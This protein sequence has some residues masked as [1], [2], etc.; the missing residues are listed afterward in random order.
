MADDL[1]DAQGVAEDAAETNT[2]AV[3]LA[4]DGAAD[5]RFGRAVAENRSIPFAYTDWGRALK[6]RGNI[7]G[8]IAKF[9]IAHDKAPHFADPLEIWGEALIAQNRSDLALAKFEEANKYAPNWGR[10]HLKWGEALW[11]SGDKDGARKQFAAASHLD[12]APAEQSQL[13]KFA[14]D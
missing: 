5:W 13:A 7:D 9:A 6:T 4:L 12:M 11:W 1:L 2:A 3:A 14:R 10:L 8:A